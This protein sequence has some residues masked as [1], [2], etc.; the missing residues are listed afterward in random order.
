MI[1]KIEQLI[2][3]GKFRNFNSSG[4]VSFKKL[5]LI[6]AVNGG[7]KTTL[8]SVL[9]SLTKNDPVLIQ[10]RI[11][12]NATIPQVAHILERKPTGDIHH[13]FNGMV[14]TS[15][16]S[17]IEVFDVHFVHENIYSGF[18]FNDEH[19]KHLHE[20]VIGAQGVVIQNQINQNKAQKT[21]SR[22]AQTDLSNQIIAA[23]GNS[24]TD[25]MIPSFLSI[26]PSL[27]VDIDTR[28]QTAAIALSHAQ[29]NAVIQT[30]STPT[31]L[32]RITHR[33]D[34]TGF[35]SDLQSS[36]AILQ[37]AALNSLFENHCRQL[38]TNG[39]ANP[40]N[41]LRVGFQYVTHKLSPA[42]VPSPL[43]C[44]FC[45]QP[46]NTTLDVIKAYTLKFNEAFNNLVARLQVY[47]DS[48]R[49][50]NIE[51]ILIGFNSVLTQNTERVVAWTQFLPNTVQS[52]S[53]DI[54]QLSTIL[55]SA[56]QAISTSIVTKQ[57]NPTQAVSTSEIVAFSNAIAEINR[58]IDSYN[59]DVQQYNVAINLAKSQIQSLDQ[60]QAELEQLTRTKLRFDPSMT[61]LCNQLSAERQRLNALENAYPDLVRQQE[62]AASAFFASYK[63]R[64]NYYLDTIFKT[65][66]R[67]EDVVHIPPVGRANYSKLGYKLTIDG[68]DISFDLNATNGVKE[69]LSEGDRSTLALALFLSKLDIDPDLNDKIIIFDDPLS[70]F[71]TNRRIYTISQ[72]QQLLQ[73]IS[74][75]IILSHNEF[76]LAELA[77]GVAAGEKKY[78]QIE[79]DFVAKAAHI[80]PLDLDTL[81]ENEYFKQ[82]KELDD[83][84]HH[85]DISKRE[86]IIGLLR[87][88]LE[89]HLRFKFYRHFAA[90]PKE[91]QTLGRLID[92]L[93]QQSIPF[94]DNANRIDVLAKM[95]IINGIS[96]RPH[97][98]EPIP[99]MGILP[100]NSTSI[101]LPQLDGL[102]TDEFELLDRML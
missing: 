81:V 63:N 43:M 13:H 11:S 18:E 60:A 44:P 24:L 91:Q 19:R 93:D 86:H 54:D 28:I 8:S 90:L 77:K 96:C 62:T 12:T 84:R 7:G 48:L 94:R 32:S 16:L 9:R 29:A 41:W 30:L 87:T 3:I 57:Q 55:R 53:L 46:I 83:F 37:D 45:N 76:F 78:L 50:F 47:V 100:F 72:I 38:T 99:D 51:S 21:A 31:S 52:P 25:G 64:V 1:Q 68:Q 56:T 74:Q 27:A 88:I 34:L 59:S 85:P 61:S 89:A 97:H 42:Q 26:S 6:Y 98:G 5:T 71:D 95:R 67:I 49:T 33:L 92:A 15:Y 80:A 36:S 17:C 20:F 75:V 79:E 40:E 14:W 22:Q 102:I 70:S 4:D 66:F 39:I 82:I 73:R 2:S 101:S 65:P 10:R 58:T 69:C 35:T 23:V